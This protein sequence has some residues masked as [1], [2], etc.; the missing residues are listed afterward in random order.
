MCGITCIYH[1]NGTPASHSQIKRMNDGIAHRGPDGEG[2]YIEGNLALGHRRLAVIDLT[3][4]GH[5][6]M[7][8]EDKQIVVSY[9]GEIYNY[10]ELR[11]ELQAKGH[12]FSSRTDTEVLIH[13]YEEY[14]IDFITRLNG[15]FAFVLWDARKKM[16]YW[17]RDRY[18]IKPLY[19]WFD[20]KTLLLASEIKAILAHPKV[21]VA[22]DPDALNEYFTFQ[23]MFNSTTLF[24]DIHLI[25][26][27]CVFSL[28]PDDT[29]I[30]SRRYWDYKYIA[31]DHS[32]TEQE[33]EEETMRLLQQAVV[34]QLMSDVPVGSHLSGGMDSGSIV[35]IASKMINRLS[36]FTCG[37]HMHG[38]CGHEANYDERRE[39]EFLANL[40]KTRHY[41]M[42]LSSKDIEW[43]LPKVIYHLEDLR[44][45]MSYPQYYIAQLASKFVKVCLSGTGGD[46]LY[47]GYPWRYYRIFRSIDREDFYREYYSFWQRLVQEQDKDQL[48]TSD[49]WRDV[50]NR[51]TF[52]TFRNVFKL[53]NLNYST[54]ED[55]I[56][57][58]LYFESKTFLHGLLLV[59][60]KLSMAHGIEERFPFMDNDLV[61]FALRIPIRYK[62][63]NLARMKRLDENEFRKLRRYY[64]EYDDG[65]NVLRRAMSRLIPEEIAQRKKQ[66][67]SSP[68]E[69]WYR[70]ETLKYVQN[71]L[72][73]K[74]SASKDYLHAEYVKKIIDEHA[75]NQK[76]NRLLIWSFLCFEW[77]CRIFLEKRPIEDE[78]YGRMK[79]G[80]LNDPSNDTLTN[81]QKTIAV[82]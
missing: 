39:A 6:P 45:G 28:K 61:D 66:G 75:S 40:C 68:E 65:K 55:H 36:T 29:T 42:V 78:R 71:L 10:Q 44:I 23:N 12:H 5:Q 30:Q 4:A 56:A 9:N 19:Q 64:L 21:S 22:V 1:L 16:L 26:S 37:F 49:L 34:R 52:T 54:P 80:I 11:R 81:I 58:S 76:N 53:N 50:N 48:F 77:W 67:F 25:T 15:M 31:H 51:D 63:G 59:G 74:K 47:A 3:S 35:S 62:L 7:M 2:T 38:V 79:D 18:G 70:G 41:E 20:G 13:G 73:D 27:A 8:S 46:E 43:V 24:K 33:A 82:A 14:G 60:D 69:S 57:N 32:M 72:L 17:A